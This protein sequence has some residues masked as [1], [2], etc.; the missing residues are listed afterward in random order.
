[1]LIKKIFIEVDKEDSSIAIKTIDESHINDLMEWKN[2]NREYFFNNYIITSEQQLNWYK[3]YIQR[4]NDFMFV[5]V[6]ND[7]SVGCMGIRK[8]DNEWDVYNVILGLSKY[9]G[10]GIMFKC[11]QNMLKYINQLDNL[12]ISLK[13]LKNN[14]AIGWYEKNGFTKRKEDINHFEMIFQG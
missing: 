5:V 2:N 9:G 13:V 4:E 11:F 6:V 3:N 12:P 1:M 8:I 10:N 14:P 7:V